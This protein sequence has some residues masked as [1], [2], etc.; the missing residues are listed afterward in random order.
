MLKL[1]RKGSAQGVVIHKIDRSARNLK[2]WADLGDCID[3]GIEVHFANEALDLNSRGG[4]L[5][6]DIQAVVAADYIRNLREEAKK[7]IYGRLKQGFYPSRAPIGYQDNGAAKPKTTDPVKGPLVRKAF[8]LYATTKFSIPTLQDELFRMGLRNN[9]GGR[10]TRAGISVMLNNP[11]YIGLIRIKR[12]GQM[13]QGNQEPLISKHL[14]DR[15][16]GIL[17]GRFNTRTKIHE[18]PFRRLIKCRSCGYSLIGELKKGRVYY[19]CHTK[20]CPTT[21]IRED[22]IEAVVTTELAKLAFNADERAYLTARIAELKERWIHDKEQQLTNLRVKHEQASERLTRL[23]DAYLDQAIERDIFEERKAALLFERQALAER[24]KDF[25]GNRVSVPDELRRFIELAGDAYSLYQMALPEKKRR[26]VQI[27]TSNFTCR[28]RTL[29]FALKE[30][31]REVATREKSDDGGPSKAVHRTLDVL[32]SSLTATA[33]ISP[34]SLVA[35]MTDL[36]A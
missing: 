27:V 12:T 5:S 28:E 14:F 21:S 25:S 24:I 15:V 29:D 2:D 22:T 11:F 18:F 4:R 23:T 35:F 9:V 19:R 6:A 26:L 8:E 34:S 30:P 17:E 3:Q 31:F 7:G 13:F 32:L 20:A 33:D 10:V 36:L 1:L 16:Q